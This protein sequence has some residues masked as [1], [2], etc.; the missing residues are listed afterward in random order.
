MK[1]KRGASKA[2][3]AARPMK[4]EQG[5]TRQ[6]VAP[7]VALGLAAVSLAC[8]VI[9]VTAQGAAPAGRTGRAGPGVAAAPIVVS[10]RPDSTV[11]GPEIRLGE[12]AD[13]QGGD[14][15]AIER[16][17]AVQVA[18][19][20]LPGL[21]RSLDASY[22]KARLRMAQVDMAGLVLDFPPTVSVTTVG[23]QIS[24]ADL[25]SAVREHIL[26]ARPEDA[27]RLSVQPSA[28]P[29][30]LLVPAGRLELRV[31]SKAAAE[32]MGTVSATVEAWVDGVMARTVSVPVR[33]GLVAE[34]LVAARPI[35]RAQT[36]GLD[37]VRIERRELAAGQES[38]REPGAALG[39][40]AV[41]NIALGEPVLASLV[42]DPPL[43]RRGDIVQLR[44]EGRGVRAVTQ[45]EA[46]EDGKAGEVIRVRSLTSNR[47]V[48][49]QVDAERSVRV[50]F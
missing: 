11:R 14:A 44:A 28:T 36:I 38:L 26:A 45:G 48:Y 13:V 20:P 30:P 42:N 33:V 29:P 12:I 8:V 46:K 21:T 2:T 35:A 7:V 49:G 19:A 39:R 24:A 41:R 27:L 18:K 1:D 6:R 34:V 47:E 5:T 10:L 43:V 25:I 17:R 23:Q 3:A 50:Q 4:I 32:L 9:A 22:L 16:L 40:R 37:D 31:R 15:A